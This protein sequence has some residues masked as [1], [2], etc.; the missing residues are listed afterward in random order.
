MVLALKKLGRRNKDSGIFVRLKK[1][2]PSCSA[3]HVL[4]VPFNLYCCICPV[5]PVLFYLSRSGCTVLVPDSKSRN[6]PEVVMLG[7]G[8]LGLL[9]F[10]E[11]GTVG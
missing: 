5:L 3:C 4:L 11:G 8:Q 7:T 6:I 1:F 2:L 10:G 9:E